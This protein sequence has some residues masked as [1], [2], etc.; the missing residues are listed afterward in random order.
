MP[1]HRLSSDVLVNIVTRLEA[2]QPKGK[3]S[4]EV[5]VARSKVYKIEQNLWLWGTPYPPDS[6]RSKPGPAST[7]TP[8]E[9]KVSQ[10]KLSS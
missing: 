7:L 10:Y 5:G 6:M 8:A 3:I 4:N 9:V 1:A 2:G